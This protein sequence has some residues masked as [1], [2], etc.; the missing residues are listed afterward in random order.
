MENVD[1]PHQHIPS[2]KPLKI[3]MVTEYF[4][5]NLGG[6]AENV[7]HSSRRLAQRGH[8]VDVITPK[9]WWHGSRK[10]DHSPPQGLVPDQRLRHVGLAFPIV[11]NNSFGSVT[12]SPLIGISLARLQKREQYDLVHLHTP[13]APVLPFLAIKYMKTVRIG[14]VHT[15]FGSNVH[16]NIWANGIRAYL[17]HLSGMIAVSPT[18]AEAVGKYYSSEF[19]IIP[20]GVDTGW[21][22][23]DVKPHPGLSDGR[24]NILYVGR[25]DPRN[26]LDFL[27]QAFNRLHPRHPETRLVIMGDGILRTSYQ[28][29]VRPDCRE[30]VHFAG[31]INHERPAFYAASQMLCLPALLS[32]FGITLLEG[33]AAGLPIVASRIPGFTDVMTENQEGLMFPARDVDKLVEALETMIGNPGLRSRFSAGGLATAARYDW[34]RVTDRIEHYY[35]KILSRENP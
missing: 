12:L 14:T 1:Q 28:T 6:I 25:L 21:F 4:Y 32:S 13:F 31:Y 24:F 17:S 27:I 20:N 11:S 16:A 22:Q 26:G 34:D 10:I 7:Y 18:A 8:Q 23:K 30:A 2:G 29:M 35:F 3:A 5:P 19:E 15:N 9:V 33:M